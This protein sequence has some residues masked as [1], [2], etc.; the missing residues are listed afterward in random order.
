VWKGRIYLGTRAGYMIA[1]QAPPPP[2]T[3]T[4]APTTSATH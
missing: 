3:P 1:L 4:T 2:N